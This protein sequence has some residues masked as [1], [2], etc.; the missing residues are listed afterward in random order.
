MTF[1]WQNICKKGQKMKSMAN[2]NFDTSESRFDLGSLALGL[3]G[4][5]KN[6]LFA[7]AFLQNQKY[8]LLRCVL[9]FAKI[10]KIL[11]KSKN[12]QIGL[13]GKCT[14]CLAIRD[15]LGKKAHLL[16]SRPCSLKKASRSL[17]NHQINGRFC[18]S[19]N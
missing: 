9:F 8:K 16:C 4:G 6:G 18:S 10:W 14:N 11:G 15:Q 12:G 1:Y 2:E 13:A 19:R 3:V 17:S 7:T 5:G